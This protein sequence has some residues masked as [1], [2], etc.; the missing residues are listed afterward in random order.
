MTKLGFVWEGDPRINITEQGAEITYRG[1]QPVMDKG[2]EN[3]A[4]ISLFTAEDWE[5]N[6]LLTK[7]FEKLGSKYEKIATEEAITLTTLDR[8]S[9]AARQA[10]AWMIPAKVAGSIEAESTNPTGR[11]LNTVIKIFPPGGGDPELLQIIRNGP[12]WIAQKLD[13]AHER[14]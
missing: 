2:L 10:L 7:E 14:L 5:G 9:A 8:L 11:Q 3:A 1:G 4:I 13:P 12:N 6:A